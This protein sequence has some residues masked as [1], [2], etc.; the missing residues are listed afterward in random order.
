MLVLAAAVVVTAWSAAERPSVPAT[1]AVEARV[2]SSCKPLGP[3]VLELDARSM[4]TSGGIPLEFSLRPL[5]EMESLDWRWEVSPELTVLSGERDG[6]AATARGEASDGRLVVVEPANGRY[7]KATLV[8]SGV[9]TGSDETG[10]TFDEP[11]E[12]QRSVTWGQ[13]PIPADVVQSRDETGAVQEFAVVP[14][15]HT[16]STQVGGR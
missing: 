3:V 12:F 4:D 11:F 6:T 5:L 14:T 16:A 13:V 8:V 1:V 10:A 9:F 2:D 15:T 7:G